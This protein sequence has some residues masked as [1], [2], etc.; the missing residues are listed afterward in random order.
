MQPLFTISACCY[1]K[2]LSATPTSQTQL[3]TPSPVTPLPKIEETDE[4][5]KEESAKTPS[6]EATPSTLTVTPP[7]TPTTPDL[8]SPENERKLVHSKHKKSV[9][10]KAK[11]GAMKKLKKLKKADDAKPSG[12]SAIEVDDEE[13]EIDDNEGST[14]DTTDAIT[15]KDKPSTLP[16]STP[17]SPG[18]FIRNVSTESNDYV[19]VSLNNRNYGSKCDSMAIHKLSF[20]SYTQS[21]CVATPTGHCLTFEFSLQPISRKPQ[22]M[23]NYWLIIIIVYYQSLMID[24]SNDSVIIHDSSAEFKRQLSLSFDTDMEQEL[25]GFHVIQHCYCHYGNNNV[26]ITAMKYWPINGL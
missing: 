11:K 8:L 25:P 19:I 17:P 18:I 13:E 22:V 21:L 23:N 24:L 15:P 5:K 20:S 4:S 6:S 2:Q 1:F 10:N 3:T 7:A 12:E 9:F 14:I 16:L 26:D